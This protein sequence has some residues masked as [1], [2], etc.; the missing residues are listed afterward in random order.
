MLG[1]IQATE[2]LKYLIGKGEL[3]VNRLLIFDALNMKFRD[4]AVKK[5]PRCPLCGENPAIKGLADEE[6]PVCDLKSRPK[7]SRRA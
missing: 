3:L 2:A 5:N 1:T 4:V 6:Q 7:D